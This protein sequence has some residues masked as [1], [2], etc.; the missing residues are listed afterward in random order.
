MTTLTAV[1][2]DRYLPP[3]ATRQ[4][5]EAAIALFEQSPQA[6]VWP[7]LD[8]TTLVAELRDRV[9]NPF[10]VNQGGQPFCGPAVVLFELV[11]T[12][13][14]K[15]VQLCE[16]LFQT[17]KFQGKTQTIVASEKLRRAS[18]GNLLMSQ[19]DWMV[20][21][22][23]RESEN[24][25]FPVEP[26]APDLIRNLAGM[27]KSWE[28]IGWIEELLGYSQVK[29]H[30]A[31]L[32]NDLNALQAANQTLQAGGIAIALITAETLLQNKPMPPLPTHWIGLLGGIQIDRRQ[33]HCDLYTWSQKLTLTTDIESFKKYFWLTI[34][35][36][37]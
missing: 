13:P 1:P 23:L 31:Y 21:A 8:K 5:A 28:L 2:A 19:V 32:F 29:Y 27:T 10:Q 33:V 9:H 16:S 15:Y 34:T 6:G 22:T 30:P 24:L 25:L 14:V 18:R 36:Q 37:P 3:P 26:N 20:L 4:A 17:G 12:Q 35:A 11:R 7:F